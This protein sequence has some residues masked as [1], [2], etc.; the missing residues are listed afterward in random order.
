ML[1][2][3]E[4]KS[5]ED[6]ILSKG[7]IGYRSPNYILKSGK[8]T[9][10]SKALKLLNL[11]Q[12]LKEL[13]EYKLFAEFENHSSE[14]LE[15]LQTI[16][17]GGM[18]VSLSEQSPFKESVPMN[19][20]EMHQNIDIYKS[21]VKLPLMDP[22]A[23]RG[24][25]IS[26]LLYNTL[27]KDFINGHSISIEGYLGT[28]G[29]T[30]KE[31][32]TMDSIP[33][34]T[35]EF[36]PY[37]PEAIFTKSGKEYGFSGDITI[38]NTAIAPEWMKGPYSRKPEL[39]GF[40][41]KLV[42][43]LFPDE[44]T[45]EQ[46]LD[47][48]HY[49]V[50]SR[51]G[52]VLCLAGDRGTGK[53]TFTE[54]LSYLVG[55]KYAEIVNSSVLKEKFNQQFKDKRLILFE[56]VA[57][58][59]NASVGKIKA[60]CNSR[61]TI[62]GKGQNAYSSE[63]FTSIVFLVNNLTDLQIMPQERRFSIPVIAEENLIKSIPVKEIAAFKNGLEAG[64]QEFYDEISNFG[65][66]LKNRKP[67]LSRE[68]PIRGVNFDRVVKTNLSEW[69]DMFIEHIIHHGEAGKTINLK[70]IFPRSLREDKDNPIVVPR[71]RSAYEEFLR[72]YRHDGVTK[73]ADVVDLGAGYRGRIN[74]GIMP[75]E[76]FLVKFSKK[77]VVEPK[78]E[79]LL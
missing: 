33:Y 24:P 30:R 63:N 29:L 69:K 17:G 15:I 8:S 12:G 44:K 68:Q 39:S 56:E 74:Y 60:F 13:G 58:G 65:E 57:L 49:A 76:E 62:E 36:N 40:I 31:V 53:T 43:H 51:N 48:A 11:P 27:N 66:F 71:K 41:G 16:V 59:D 20:R 3:K 32:A 25:G 46:V 2:E 19:I 38:L 21:L 70:D 7:Y 77:K 72:D 75:R 52:T 34:V 54:V 4:R 50:F 61:I 67:S 35:P 42:N 73:M 28:L 6:Y 14:Y 79:D 64:T 10:L 78:G 9:S 23:E 55:P 47:W 45:R 1:T 18:E 5:I 22:G 26:I 37:V